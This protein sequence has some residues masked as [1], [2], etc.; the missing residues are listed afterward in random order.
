MLYE[1]IT[2][3]PPLTSGR[4]RFILPSSSGKTRYPT[5][6]L[7][8]R[9]ERDVRVAERFEIY[10]GGLELCNGFEELTDADEQRRRFEQDLKRSYNFV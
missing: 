9:S 3:I 1:V 4:L 2:R 8:R 7:A 5:I 6:R 10:I